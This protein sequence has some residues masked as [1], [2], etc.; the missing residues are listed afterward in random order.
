MFRWLTGNKREDEEAVQEQKTHVEEGLKRTRQT[1][2]GRMAATLSSSEITPRLWD[3]LEEALLGADVGFEL[4]EEL[5]EQLKRR[6]RDEGLRTG[7]DVKTALK[8]ELV[9][10]LGSEADDDADPAPTR[11]RV[12]MVVGVNGSGK[13][14]TIAKLAHIIQEQGETVLLAA[15]DTFRAGAIDQLKLWGERLKVDVIAHEPGADPGAVTFDALKA[16]QNRGRDVVLVDTAGR[17]HTKSNLMEELKKV[18]RVVGRALPDTI[19]EVLLV[20]DATTGQNG[21]SQAQEFTKAVQV[22]GTILTKLDGTAKGGIVFAIQKALGIPVTFI[23]V[24]EQMGDLTPFDAETFVDV[25]FE[26][27]EY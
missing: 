23:G 26:E 24:G 27:S 21:L 1:L 11:P 3:D 10:H 25:F 13:T 7:S 20:L 9:E 5:I 12:V 14:T 22:N 17:L 4:A 19:P 18:H 15:A 8:E 6:A 16:A 2:F